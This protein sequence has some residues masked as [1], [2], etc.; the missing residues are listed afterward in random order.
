LFSK[1]TNNVR[2]FLHKNRQCFLQ[3]MSSL[4]IP[5]ICIMPL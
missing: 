3:K 2:V 1:Q 5:P 4:S